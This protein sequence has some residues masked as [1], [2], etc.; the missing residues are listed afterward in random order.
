V[1]DGVALAGGWLMYLCMLGALA[2][3]LL[4]RQQ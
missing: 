3:V 2:F 4:R 1:T